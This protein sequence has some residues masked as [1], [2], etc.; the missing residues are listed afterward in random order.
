MSDLLTTT[1]VGTHQVRLDGPDKVRG[2]APYAYEHPLDD[3]LFL[4]PVQAQ[5]ARGRAAH[6]DVSAVEA[7][8]GVVHVLTHDN[9]PEPADTDDGELAI[10]RSAEIGFRGQYLGAVIATT[11]EQARH[12]AGLV[13]ITYVQDDHDVELREDHPDSREPESGSGDVR[14]GD[15]D[16]ALAEAAVSID[17]RYSTPMEHNN[18]HGT[19]H[20]RR[21][22]GRR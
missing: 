11:P 9:A 5:I 17:A 6:I 16:A 7:A 12:A 2:L 15:V 14:A 13:E 3:P 21:P 22:L 10:L 19:A 1:S 18:P 4:Y 8:D 20:H